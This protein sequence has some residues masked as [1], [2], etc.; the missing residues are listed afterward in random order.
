MRRAETFL[1][2]LHE[3]EDILQ[4][5]WGQAE[6]ARRRRQYIGETT[7]QGPEEEGHRS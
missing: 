5:L 4:R 2:T 3:T 1:R 7:T 6:M